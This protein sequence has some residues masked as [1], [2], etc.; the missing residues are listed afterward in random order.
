MI[1]IKRW[2]L[3]LLVG[4][5]P[6]PTGLWPRGRIGT[7]R[8]WQKRQQLG[9]WEQQCMQGTQAW[10][11]LQ[12]WRTLRTKQPQPQPAG[13]GGA[14]AGRGRGE[15]CCTRSRRQEQGHAEGKGAH[16][17][18]GEGGGSMCKALQTNEASWGN[19]NGLC[20]QF[21]LLLGYA[22]GPQGDM[23]RGMASVITLGVGR[24]S[25]QDN[26]L[27]WQLL[28]AILTPCAARPTA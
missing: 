11:W 23:Q 26:Y 24:S 4:L 14:E 12:P 9:M 7:A 2:Q 20:S 28:L 18:V 6:I 3:P 22:K 13:I 21:I 25:C 8:R 1:V 27:E 17:D 19:C 15:H 16:G 5:L 10:K